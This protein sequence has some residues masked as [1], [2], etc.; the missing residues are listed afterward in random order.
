M[1]VGVRRTVVPWE[2][3]LCLQR[4]GGVQVL[5]VCEKMQAG[6]GGWCTVLGWEVL[7]PI[8]KGLECHRKD[9]FFFSSG[10]HGLRGG[11]REEVPK[12]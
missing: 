11:D 1:G 5:G 7:G 4:H 8:V 9:F 12:K 10:C 3:G 6:Q 2:E